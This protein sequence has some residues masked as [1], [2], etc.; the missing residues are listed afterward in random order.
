MKRIPTSEKALID[1]E[2][3]W[4]GERLLKQGLSVPQC[5]RYLYERIGVLVW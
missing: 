4:L 5:T 2:L 3:L 1:S